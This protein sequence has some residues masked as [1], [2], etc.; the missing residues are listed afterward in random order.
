MIP[1]ATTIGNTYVNTY[2]NYQLDEEELKLLLTRR[3]TQLSTALNYKENGIFERT[4][5]QNGQQYFGNAATPD[6][7]RFVY[8][9]VIV[10]G[11]IAAGANLAIAHGISTV[12]SFTHIYGTCVTAGPTYRAIPYASVTANA[13]IE[14][15][16]DP[17]NVT[18]F[19]GAASPNITSAM[20]VLEYLKQ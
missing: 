15:L 20:I 8:R 10:F 16:V 4:E 1:Q 14:V 6:Q 11:A 17:T 13:N 19:N 5:Y 7:K 3:D 12:S 9:K 18:I 2:T